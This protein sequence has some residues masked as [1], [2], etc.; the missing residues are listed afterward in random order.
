MKTRFDTADQALGAFY[1]A[2]Q[3]ADLKAMMSTWLNDDEIACIHP[4]SH[5]I[6]GRSAIEASW[7]EILAAVPEIRIRTETL[8][9]QRDTNLVSFTVLE[10]IHVKGEAEPRPPMIATNIFHKSGDDWG[11]VLHH[12]SPP[13]PLPRQ[14]PASERGRVH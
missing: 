4:M 10:H 12:A 3:N 9:Q 8:F 7:A 2:F 5:A 11:M 14:K 1:E 6:M 13:G